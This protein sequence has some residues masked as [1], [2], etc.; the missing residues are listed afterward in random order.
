MSLC[1]DW[2]ILLILSGLTH[3][4]GASDGQVGS[5]VDLGEGLLHNGRLAGC[6][7]ML[8]A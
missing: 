4:S 5:S 6:R 1:V 8:D 2:A 3:V 7:L